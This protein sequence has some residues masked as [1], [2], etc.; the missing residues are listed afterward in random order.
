MVLL[1][2]AEKFEQAQSL[3]RKMDF[4]AAMPLLQELTV[5]NSQLAHPWYMLGQCNRFLGNIDK[6]VY[7]LEAAISLEK[8]I[9]AYFLALGI[10][11][12]LSGKFEQ[13]LDSLR[14][15]T[16]LDKNYVEPFMSAAMTFQKMG[17]FEKAHEVYD[18]AMKAL[19][20]QFFLQTPNRIDAPIFGLREVNGG[21]W[22]EYAFQAIL[23]QAA[24][25]RVDGLSWPSEQFAINEYAYKAHGGLMWKDIIEKDGK[26]TRLALPNYFDTM[27]EFLINDKRYSLILGDIY[28]VKIKLGESKECI[29]Y[30]H[31][32]SEFEFLRE[33]YYS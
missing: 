12:Q 14:A 30:E 23:Y 29:K 32:A 26:K 21:L 27:R 19:T 7:F 9:P 20:R 31:E 11:Y 18:G 4:L 17:D 6:A 16:N 10:A 3:F 5:E 28:L 8:S 2:G 33:K 15:A 24:L 1:T 13:S 25:S 22:A